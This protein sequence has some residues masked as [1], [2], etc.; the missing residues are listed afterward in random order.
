MQE[1]TISQ[2][3]CINKQIDVYM[4]LKVVYPGC[5]ITTFCIFLSAPEYTY[6]KALCIFAGMEYIWTWMKKEGRLP[7]LS[8]AV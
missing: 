4:S 5:G 7:G 3:I 1:I 6:S 8:N 2:A